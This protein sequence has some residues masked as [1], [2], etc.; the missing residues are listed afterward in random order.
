MEQFAL[1]GKGA[2]T[3]QAA[4]AWSP[5]PVVL[6]QIPPSRC[7]VAPAGASQTAAYTLLPSAVPTPGQTPG[8]MSQGADFLPQMDRPTPCAPSGQSPDTQNGLRAAGLRRR[9]QGCWL[10]SSST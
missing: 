3:T 9:A 1:A 5:L 8:K 7:T 2:V 10:N 6:Q 4:A